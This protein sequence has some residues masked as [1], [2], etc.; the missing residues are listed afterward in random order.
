MATR[1]ASQAIALL[2][3]RKKKE[4]ALASSLS[5][6]LVV[7]ESGGIGF[8]AGHFPARYRGHAKQA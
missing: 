3:G 4:D 1:G 2:P 5:G 8:L 6:F 7:G